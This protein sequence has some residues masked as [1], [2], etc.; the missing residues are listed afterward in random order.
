VAGYRIRR[1]GVELTT[2]TGTSYSD[3][4]LNA[5]TLYSYTV[6]AYDN[7]SNESAQTSP[8]TATTQAAGG[9]SGQVYQCNDAGANHR[10]VIDTNTIG[11]TA[12]FPNCANMVAVPFAGA[13]I[14]LQR[15]HPNDPTDPFAVW[16]PRANLPN[17][18]PAGW[19]FWTPNGWQTLAQLQSGGGGRQGHSH[20]NC[21]ALHDR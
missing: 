15:W 8:A 7:A 19:Y 5:S 12:N 20:H 21:Q 6:T 3:T 9:T 10:L 17:D 1:G 11:R 2:V 4:G 14:T 13:G 16:Q 18:P